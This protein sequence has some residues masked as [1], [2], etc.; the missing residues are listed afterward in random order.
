MMKENFNR[1][2]K[3]NVSVKLFLADLQN[4]LHEGNVMLVQVN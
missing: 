4:E 3:S 1:F 2:S